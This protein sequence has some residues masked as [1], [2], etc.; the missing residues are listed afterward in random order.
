MSRN[1]YCAVRRELTNE[2]V[3]KFI[4]CATPAQM[5]S[6]RA[7]FQDFDPDFSDG[8]ESI[9]ERELGTICISYSYT[10]VESLKAI[11]R[12]ESKLKALCHHFDF[13]HIDIH[14]CI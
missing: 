9:D 10:R 1:V 8:I 13:L 3:D 11:S 5:A 4:A 14:V 6:Y 2:R 12:V 7:A